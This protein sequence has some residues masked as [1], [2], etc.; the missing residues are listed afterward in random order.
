MMLI[1]VF[2]FK[3][4]S[5]RTPKFYHVIHLTTRKTTILGKVHGNAEKS[6]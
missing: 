2:R 4:S 1:S 3:E 6:R 5:F